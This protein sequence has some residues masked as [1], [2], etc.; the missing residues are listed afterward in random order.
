MC[1]SGDLLVVA[2]LDDGVFAYTLDGGELKWKVSGKLPEMERE[3]DARGPTADEEGRLFVCDINNMCVHALSALDGTHLG[4]VLRKG[5]DDVGLPYKV[6][7][8]NESA[9]LIVA[10][11]SAFSG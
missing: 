7:W 11:L 5:E 4:V 1:T 3:I 9:S 10:H 2:R 6:I 8:H